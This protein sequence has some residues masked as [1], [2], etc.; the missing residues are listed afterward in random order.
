MKQVINFIEKNVDGC[1]TDVSV[2]IMVDTDLVLTA[3]HRERL[4]AAIEEI[5]NKLAGEWDTD[6]LINEAMV[7]VFDE[8]EYEVLLPDLTIEF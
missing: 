1:G 4:L 8:E 7:K 5:K 3:G 2:M 6:T